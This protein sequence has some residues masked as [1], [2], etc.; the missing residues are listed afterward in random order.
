MALITLLL[1]DG[2]AGG[3]NSHVL[4]CNVTPG[5]SG[6]NLTT[7]TAAH[8]M[9]DGQAA[10]AMLIDSQTASL[11]VASLQLYGEF[12]ETTTH[13][14]FVRLTIAGGFRRAGPFTVQVVR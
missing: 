7:V 11:L 9:I 8:L 1:A 14:C 13:R 3:A 6:M 4:R 10:I 2:V 5:V 12:P